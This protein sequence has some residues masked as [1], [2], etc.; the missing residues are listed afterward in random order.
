MHE[1]SGIKSAPQTT[2]R[3]DPQKDPI[4][5]TG[6]AYSIVIKVVDAKGLQCNKTLV[7]N[8]TKV[9]VHPAAFAAGCVSVLSCGSPGL[10]ALAG[11]PVSLYACEPPK[12]GTA[13]R[14]HTCLRQ[15]ALCSC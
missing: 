9:C 6:I 7:I 8:V 2:L 12:R 4:L 13:C 10:S 3:H 1:P 11:C 15:S 14:K 5:G